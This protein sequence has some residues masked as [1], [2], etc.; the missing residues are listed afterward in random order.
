MRSWAFQC[1]FWR[2]GLYDGR[3][4]SAEQIRTRVESFAEMLKLAKAARRA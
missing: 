4:Y 1:W 3:N 2:W